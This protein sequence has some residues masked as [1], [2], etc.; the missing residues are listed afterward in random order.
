VVVA[1]GA[2]ALNAYLCILQGSGSI[3]SRAAFPIGHGRTYETHR[4]GPLLVSSYHPSQQNTSTKKLTAEM[5]REIF[6]R[7]RTFLG[8]ST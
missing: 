4:G 6:E 2:I 1:L 5:L 8:S 7:C 3:R